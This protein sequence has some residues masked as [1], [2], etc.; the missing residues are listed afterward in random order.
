MTDASP[1]RS[2]PSLT[3]LADQC[4]QCGLCLPACPTYALEPL[5]TE[6]PRGRIALVKAWETG[7][8][9]PTAAGDRH[10]DQ[11]LGCRRCEAVCP[12]GVRYGE[13]LTLARSRQRARR[14]PN[15]RQRFAEA[16]TAHP[17]RLRALLALYRQVY[18][19]L[20]Q[21]WRPLPRPPAVATKPA[22]PP[23]PAAEVP[24]HTYEPRVPGAST[25]GDSPQSL[26]LFLGCI[27][28]AY[29]Q[30]LQ[31]AV[32]ALCAAAG[33]A[34]QAP[35]AQ[36][37]CGSLHAHAGDLAQAERLAARNRIAFAA[38]A[39]VLTLASGCHAQ[40]ETALRGHAQAVDAIAWLA[41]RA[42][43]LRFAP[44]P[45]RIALHLPCT[46]RNSVKS[47]A[48]LRG[49][50]ARVPALEVVALDAGFGCCG[51]AGTQML[52]APTRA[53]RF[54]QPL[55]EQLA[56]SGATRL[57]SANIGCRLHLGN[58]TTLPV[59]HPLEFLAECLA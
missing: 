2:E 1:P 30:A 34:V 59:Q 42:D 4:V 50:L 53:A 40:V 20:P 43:A 49:L 6:S 9:A 15:R 56:A 25:G 37:C 17:R 18:P 16:L 29:E 23:N 28:P 44:R 46:Q 8:A 39:T 32:A 3:A 45:E 35:I 12:A 58:G 52:S 24:A 38:G 51:A 21:A 13:I 11:C 33:A 41:Q 19:L 55:L 10:L 48:A 54:R 26:S 47:D 31:A 7:S 27:A 5:E 22:A 57:L 36:T 14:Q